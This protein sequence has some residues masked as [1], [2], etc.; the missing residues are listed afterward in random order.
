MTVNQL[1][2]KKPDMYILDKILESFKL[3]NIHDTTIF[4][5]KDLIENNTVDKLNHII[6]EFNKYYL[7][8]KA[9][10]YL[11]NLNEKKAVTILRQFVKTINYYIFSK[12][13]YIDGE[14]YITYQI[15]PVD[16]KKILKLRKKDEL[17]L[18]S[19]D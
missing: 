18:V 9:N 2:C 7:P 1:F 11:N 4:T 16:Q 17:Y 13:K 3:E 14:K 5:K 12:E 15:V 8:C 6:P 10:K 19:F